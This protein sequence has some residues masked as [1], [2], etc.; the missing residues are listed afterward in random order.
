MRRALLIGLPVAALLA[1]G[2]GG[3]WYLHHGDLVAD[4]RYR[5]AHGDFRTAELDLNSY[6][7]RHPHHPEASYRL[8]VLNLAQD[9]PVAAERN[10]KIAREG[11]FDPKSIVVPLGEAYMRQRRFDDVL[12]DFTAE[13][14]AP[15][16][17][18][19]VLT[20]RASA[21]LSLNRL[22]EARQ[23]AADAMAAAPDNVEPKLVAA[24]VELAAG[25][26]HAA[27]QRV[28][29]ALAKD[30]KRAEALLLK[31]ELC[32]HHGDVPGA[33]KYA[34]EV[35]AAN[36]NRPDAKMA[37]ARALAA[38]H[39]D[40]EASKLL[41]EV[42][43]HSPRDVGANY[44]RVILAV[45]QHD[46][47]TADASLAAISP[48][49]D[50]LPQGQYF[51]A[52]T[53]LGRNQPEQAQ[54]AA[55]KYVAR[56]PNDTAGIKLLAFAELALHRPDRAVEVLKPL[57]STGT[58]DADTLDLL[59]RS[60]AMT[61][62]MKS[63]ETNLT[64][65]AALQPENTE[66]LNRLAAAK[67]DLGDTGAGQA[68]LRRSLDKQPDQPVAAETLV[69]TA[70]AAGDIKGAS[71]TVEQLRK[72]IGDTELVGTLD[73]QVKVANLD[74]LGA[75]A[76]YEDVLKRFPDSRSATFGLVQ[77]EGRLADAK[78]AEQRLD[79]W[80]AKHPTDKQGLQLQLKA[81]GAA[82]DTKS[83]IA[84]AEA[85]HAGD[86]N[87]ADITQALAT[88]YLT[89]KQTD[90]ALGLLDRAADTP[91]PTLTS[92]H[93]QALVL[94]GRDDDARKAYQQ[95]EAAATGALWPRFGLLQLAIR[96]KDYT[97]AREV[98][99]E[100]MRMAPGNPRLLEA[101]VALDLKQNGIKAALDTAEKLKQDPQNMPAALLLSGSALEANGDLKGAADAYVAAFHEA[102][103]SGLATAAAS[104]LARA[105]RREE[106]KA[107]LTGWLPKDPKDVTALQVL[108][109]YALN[110]RRW[111][112]ASRMLDQVL[113]FDPNNPIALNN[114]AWTK[115]HAGDTA[116][117]LGYAQRAYFLTPSPETEDTLGWMLAKS[118]QTA[119]ALPLLE[120]A[121]AAKP[122]SDILYHYAYAL[123]A[124]GHTKDA[125]AALQHALAD[126]K[127]FDERSD[128]Q[129]MLA[130]LPQ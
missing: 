89:N 123:Q 32:M 19:Q 55:A 66:I 24:R 57:T 113:V 68:E 100:A 27:D 23:A 35:L 73:A 5:M 84:A 28:D 78:S 116:A 101:A 3:Y 69:Q 42:L 39:H 44:L 95:A 81:Y 97:E 61:G 2:A 82:G 127:P 41:D 53:K 34:Q 4:A 118:S 115:L 1:F 11:N 8:G 71:A 75:K 51:L 72:A 108:A 67:L 59:A 65:A 104:A 74:L 103:S 109:S 54:E 48:V 87:D 17:K 9:N 36:P 26:E 31:G 110:D 58:P 124:E 130:G 119:K 40:L 105:G 114:A 106:A 77:A 120:Q 128:A 7:R 80:M 52:I 33:L 37:A 45:R 111:Y 46:F 93:A 60:Q 38:Q 90:K 112:D 20:V 14:A 79:G 121:A 25:D 94:A 86:P 125:K 91:N 92:L 126:A 43:K 122:K 62:D 18:S 83:A 10:L 13:S 15:G 98:L 56:M 88:L 117:A 99:D 12:T 76:L 50:K 96:Q 29:E 70:L 6:L 129:A 30:P 63:A 16:T 47:A 21:Y 107:L 49:V 64:K 85:A 22:A 102:P